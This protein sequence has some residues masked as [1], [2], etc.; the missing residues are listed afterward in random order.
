[1]Y[2]CLLLC[3]WMICFFV[4]SAMC[5]GVMSTTTSSF[6]FSGL[7]LV[8]SGGPFLVPCSKSFSCLFMLFFHIFLIYHVPVIFLATLTISWLNQMVKSRRIARGHG[9]NEQSSST[10]PPQ[11][12]VE[13]WMTTQ[14]H[15][16]Q[17]M[18]QVVSNIQQS[19]MQPRDSHAEF[20]KGHPPVFSHL[21]EPLDADDW[22]KA[23]ERQ[24]NIAQCTDREKV[25]YALGQLQGVA[26]DWWESYT[27]PSMDAKP[28]LGRSSRKT[29]DH[30]MCLKG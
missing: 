21:A 7:L 27:S 4:L 29:S 20:M 23:V 18:V 17:G 26:L 28:P 25:L 10:P 5:C 8:C 15:L 24:L 3:H 13:Q 22:L 2:V 6:Q 1:M 9:A 30:T 16:M 14:T 11:G 19:H 12:D